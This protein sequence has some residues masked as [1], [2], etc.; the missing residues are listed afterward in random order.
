MV[1]PFE[2]TNAPKMGC[3]LPDDSLT[4]S[5]R[6]TKISRYR[7]VLYHDWAWIPNT[8]QKPNL[9]LMITAL[10]MIGTDFGAKKYPRGE[11]GGY[12]LSEK[13]KSGISVSTETK[14][15]IKLLTDKGLVM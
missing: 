11:G 2:W 3:R 15:P 13:W 1:C 9:F 10:L 7:Q 5:Q 12:Y 6:S 4:Q 8:P 14:S